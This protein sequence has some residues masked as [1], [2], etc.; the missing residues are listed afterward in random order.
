MDG[1]SPEQSSGPEIE[2]RQLTAERNAAMEPWKITWLLTNRGTHRLR[3]HAVRLP[4]GQFKSAEDSFD[5]AIELRPNGQTQFQTFVR[6]DEPPGEITENAFVI[7]YVAWL[8]EPWRVFARIR[9]IVDSE[10]KPL[11]T[12]ESVTTQKVGSAQEDLP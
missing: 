4:H 9:V 2:L 12:T 1:T 10:G 7:L 11:A 3:V 8:D 6:C 5:P